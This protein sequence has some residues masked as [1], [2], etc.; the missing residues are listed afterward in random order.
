MDHFVRWSDI[1][2]EDRRSAETADSHTKS[3]LSLDK[4]LEFVVFLLQL[5]WKISLSIN[6]NHCLVVGG[7]GAPRGTGQGAPLVDSG[8][9]RTL[10]RPSP[11]PLLHPLPPPCHFNTASS[12]TGSANVVLALARGSRRPQPNLCRRATWS[13]RRGGAGGWS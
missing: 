10:G 11:P 13:R 6:C 9:P 1:R 5:Q 12:F 2:T 3:Q 4:Y 7:V 8:H